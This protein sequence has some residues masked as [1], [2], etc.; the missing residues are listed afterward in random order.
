MEEKT[1]SRVLIYI[2]VVLV[3]LILILVIGGI[4]G[5]RSL[6]DK[7]EKNQDNNNTAVVD[8]SK[9]NTTI[10]SEQENIVN[11]AENSNNQENVTNVQINGKN[12]SVKVESNY[13]KT[14]EYGGTRS[15]NVTING[16]KCLGI[17]NTD[18]CYNSDNFYEIEKIK[19]NANKEY[20][21][22]I[23]NITR[24]TSEA[25]DLYIID[26]NANKIG[27]VAHDGRTAYIVNE[28]VL[29]LEINED[30]IIDYKKADTTEYSLAKHK[31]T[32]ENGK[33]V[34]TILETYSKNQVEEAGATD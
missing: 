5:Y 14:S 11:V 9:S 4:L 33:L 24:E 23:I 20:I 12:C 1:K 21:L 29:E 17:D 31:Y 6:L 27:K 8:E 32:I 3:A 22:L 26:E 28:K 18:Y 30:S 16:I 2:I 10:N 19:D 7:I 34:D 15:Y 13:I 25:N